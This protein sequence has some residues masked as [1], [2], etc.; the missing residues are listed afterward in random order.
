M[1]LFM[2]N[3]RGR[4]ISA[5]YEQSDLDWNDLG[6]MHGEDARDEPGGTGSYAPMD[7]PEEGAYGVP[8]EQL[9]RTPGGP[10]ALE[11][12]RAGDDRAFQDSPREQQERSVAIAERRT[13]WLR[14]L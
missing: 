10:E 4:F 7:A 14:A 5:E 8:L 12:W 6:R 13:S 3:P 11:R 9:L 2:W 1:R